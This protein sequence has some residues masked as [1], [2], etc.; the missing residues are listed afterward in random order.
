MDARTALNTVNDTL[1]DWA[2]FLEGFDPED[3]SDG[4]GNDRLLAYQDDEALKV[5]EATIV[6]ANRI[7][8]A[9]NDIRTGNVAGS[10]PYDIADLAKVL[11][12]KLE[13]HPDYGDDDQS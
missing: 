1:N 5:L 9:E 8:D 12:R 13:P 7:V 10:W 11:G 3:R 6:A 4:E 2:S